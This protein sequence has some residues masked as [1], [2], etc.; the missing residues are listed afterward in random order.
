MGKKFIITR[1]KKF[2]HRIELTKKIKWNHSSL[3]E[4]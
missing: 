4:T 3:V 1:W 2:S